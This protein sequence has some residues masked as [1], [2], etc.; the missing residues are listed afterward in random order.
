MVSEDVLEV[1]DNIVIDASVNTVTDALEI[2]RLLDY[3][4]VLTKDST[5]GNP[6]IEIQ[7]SNDGINWVNPYLE[8]DGVTPLAMDLNDVSNSVR[9][10]GKWVFK[11]IRVSTIP[12]GTTTGTLGYVITYVNGL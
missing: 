12:N 7:G 10:T 1:N 2:N 11:F 9:D 6:T 5:D 3:S 8:D 4:I